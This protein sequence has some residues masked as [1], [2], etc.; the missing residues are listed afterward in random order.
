MEVYNVGGD[1]LGDYELDCIGNDYDW[2]VYFYESGSYDGC[3]EAVGCKDGFL[4][5]YN[6]DHCS[7]FG[8]TEGN[9]EKVSVDKVFASDDV[10]GTDITRK[11]VKDKV[12][13]LL[14]I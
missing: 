9:P 7:C 3:G 14:E 13:E 2:F 11:D 12:A 5:I 8:P 4:Y 6:L 10:L 1:E